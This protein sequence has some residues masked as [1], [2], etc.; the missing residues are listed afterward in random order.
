MS[1]CN[2]NCQ[3]VTVAVNPSVSVSD[4]YNRLLNKPSINDVELTSH[5]QAAQLNLLTA[6]A[7]DYEEMKL[8]ESQD[9]KFI[10]VLTYGGEAKKVKLSDV[11]I[12]TVASLPQELEVGNYVFLLKEKK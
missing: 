5:S 4:D 9:D 7:E 11:K 8:G 12:K 3:R 6:K 1:D 2:K 10:L